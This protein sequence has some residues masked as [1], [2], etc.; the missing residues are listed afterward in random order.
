MWCRRRME[1]AKWSEKVN[2]EVFVCRRKKVILD[3]ERKIRTWT[4][5]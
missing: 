2:N 1:K 3:Y 5:L 4:R